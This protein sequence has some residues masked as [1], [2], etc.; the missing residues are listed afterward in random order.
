MDAA[1]IEF[2]PLADAVRTA[3]ST[4]TFFRELEGTLSG[5]L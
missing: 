1:V 3:A 4:M 2:D 5:R